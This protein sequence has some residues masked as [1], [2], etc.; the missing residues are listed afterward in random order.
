MNENNL[1]EN[2]SIT[3]PNECKQF[4]ERSKISLNEQIL[5]NMK[6]EKSN[7]KSSNFSISNELL[8]EMTTDSI[9]QNEGANNDSEKTDDILSLI[10]GE[11]IEHMDGIDHSSSDS[12]ESWYSTS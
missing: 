6:C 11:G 7:D 5:R 1:Y 8:C 3:S 9:T 12:S 4:E 2:V 10:R